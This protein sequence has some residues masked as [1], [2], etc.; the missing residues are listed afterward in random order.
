MRRLALLLAAASFAGTG[1][2]VSDTCDGGTLTVEWPS[3]LLANGD[4]TS[5]CT[6]AGVSYVDVYLDG[7][8]VQARF[9]CADGGAVIAGVQSTSQLVTVEALDASGAIVLRDEQQVGTDR[10]GDRLARF[11]PAEGALTLDY[12]FTPSDVCTAGASY[13]WFSVYDEIVGDVAARADESANTTLYSCSTAAS[14][15]LPVPI[16][17]RLPAGSYTLERIEEAVPSGGVYVVNGSYCSPIRF[18]VAGGA[19]RV[20]TVTMDTVAPAVC[21]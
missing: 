20:V 12:H 11:Q 18:P 6:A 21:P 3:F 5:S 17:F 1:C 2:V 15:P 14:Y 16:T 8:P 9:S 4:V 7:K 10:C 13:I 19:E